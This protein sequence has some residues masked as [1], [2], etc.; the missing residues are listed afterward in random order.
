MWY[1]TWEGIRIYW[2]KAR[3]M[4][5]F[6]D[7]WSA[8][9]L[10]LGMV[11]VFSACGGK[12]AAPFGQAS[13]PAADPPAQAEAPKAETRRIG[14][15]IYRFDDNFMTLYRNEMLKYFESLSGKGGVQY[16]VTV[17]DGKNDMALQEKQVDEFVAQGVDAI[18][19]NLVQ[20]SSADALIGRVAKSGIPLILINREPL[21]TAGDQSYRGIL[22]NDKVCYIGADSRLAG[23]Y[24][25]EIIRDLPGHGD[26]NGDGTVSYIMLKGDPENVEAQY[27]TEYSVKALTDAGIAVEC[28]D[29]RSGN[30][31]RE[32][33][34]EICAEDLAEYGKRVEVVFCNN[35]AMALGAADAIAAAGRAVGKDIYLV[36][37]DALEE[38]RQMVRDGA[39]TGTVF[40]D[41]VGQAHKAVDV[42]AEASNGGAMQNYYMVDFVKIVK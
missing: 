42:A 17:C 24:Q 40:N 11:L 20:T 38:C 29:E 32:K 39:M 6:T 9:L 1:P 33:G 41:H 21:G 10:A 35:D 23:R 2:G 4:K 13:T 3:E 15:C 25:G 12:P 34:K 26:L 7:R 30:W 37:V 31:L 19:L 18:I 22:D 8:L 36:G 5:H 28:L 14:V 27:R 16:D